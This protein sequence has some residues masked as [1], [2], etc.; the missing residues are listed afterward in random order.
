MSFTATAQEYTVAYGFQL[1]DGAGSPNLATERNVHWIG[2]LYS[3]I[4]KKADGSRFDL[5]FLS[6][7]ALAI[8]SLSISGIACT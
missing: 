1:I 2:A 3:M 5:L 7:V 4:L 6:F 8:V